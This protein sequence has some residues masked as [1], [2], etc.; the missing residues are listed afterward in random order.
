LQDLVFADWDSADGPASAWFPED[1]QSSDIAWLMRMMG[2]ESY[3]ALHAW[4]ISQRQKF[5]ATM[6]QRFDVQFSEPFSSALDLLVISLSQRASWR[7]AGQG[8][9]AARGL[10]AFDWGCVPYVDCGG[11]VVLD[12]ASWLFDNRECTLM[13]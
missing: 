5:W 6:V 7:E 4:S 1:P 11:R 13:N 9:P 2:E 3:R 8:V 12:C 10:I